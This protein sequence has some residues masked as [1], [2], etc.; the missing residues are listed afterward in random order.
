MQ[1]HEAV[2][3]AEKPCSSLDAEC[4]G[5]PGVSLQPYHCGPETHNPET[6]MLL[7]DS[8]HCESHLVVC[9]NE[10]LVCANAHIWW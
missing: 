8:P 7:S 1:T 6:L 3:P 2:L 5:S 4:E 10:R 9:A